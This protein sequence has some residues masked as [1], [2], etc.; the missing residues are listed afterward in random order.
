MSHKII[1]ALLIGTLLLASCGTTK[2]EVVV[3]DTKKPFLVDTKLAK[4]F[5]K[6]YTIEKSG[7][8]VG[9][10]TIALASQGVG[11]VTSVAVK[12]GASVKK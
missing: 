4:D 9:T 10:S 3:K 1:S 11:R 5:T 2:P 6:D 8:L 7:R 12:E